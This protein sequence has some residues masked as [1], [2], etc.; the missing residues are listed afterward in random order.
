MARSP[1]S[2]SAHFGKSDL[3]A[4]SR[5][6]IALAMYQREKNFIAAGIL[7]E[8]NGGDTY[9]VLHLLC[10]GIEVALKGI[11]LISDFER[12]APK[13]RTYGH[14]IAKLARETHGAFP[15]KPLSPSVTSELSALN[16]FYRRHLLRYAGM[17]DILIDPTSL[18]KRNGYSAYCCS[19]SSD[20]PS[21]E[22]KSRKMNPRDRG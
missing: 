3:S 19:H 8:R 5:R 16:K 17:Q 18:K 9:A 2:L 10:Q 22:Q 20:G 12:F 6:L 7:L 1:I 15:V 13:L 11:L 4:H 14:D 21:P